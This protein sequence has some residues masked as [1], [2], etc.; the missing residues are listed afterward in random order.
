MGFWKSQTIRGLGWKLE[1]L[2]RVVSTKAWSATPAVS[3]RAP[4]RKQPIVRLVLR[5]SI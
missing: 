3:N 4:W 1:S 2:M 5:M